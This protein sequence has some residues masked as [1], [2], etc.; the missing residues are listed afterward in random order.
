MEVELTARTLMAIQGVP[1]LLDAF[2][3][4]SERVGLSSIDHDWKGLRESAIGVLASLLKRYDERSQQ[5]TRSANYQQ[6]S[7]YGR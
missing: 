5:R 4:I 1:V 7:I 2:T 3:R 6:R